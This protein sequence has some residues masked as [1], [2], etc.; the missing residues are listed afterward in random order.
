LILTVV[1][2]VI[3]GRQRLYQRRLMFL[4]LNGAKVRILY[5][6]QFFSWEMW[7]SGIADWMTIIFW[8]MVGLCV[9]RFIYYSF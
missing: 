4:S 5:S 6:K 3:V 9:H 7:Y 1:N 2:E 8:G